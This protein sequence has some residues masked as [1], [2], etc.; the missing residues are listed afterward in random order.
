V[1]LK[2]RNVRDL[3]PPDQAEYFLKE[4]RKTVESGTATSIE[5]VVRTDDVDAETFRAG[6]EGELWFRAGISP[7]SAEVYGR[8]AVVFVPVNITSEKLRQDT[9]EH[10]ANHDSLSGLRNRRYFFEFLEDQFERVRQDRVDGLVLIVFDL[11]RFKNVN[12]TCGHLGGDLVIQSVGD[13]VRRI[14]RSTD[15]SA[16][17]G[18]EEFGVLLGGADRERAV[19][20]AEDLHQ[21]LEKQVFEAGDQRCQVTASF[22]VARTCDADRSV[23]DLYRRAD[24]ALYRSKTGGRNR[25]SVD[26]LGWPS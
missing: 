19:S 15:I 7:I 12:D 17:F 1:G 3:F 24:A 21:A 4:I 10:Q 22:G 6:P 2:G 11:D 9:L 23:S 16:R 18:G 5:Y 13:L 25:V 8:R 20:I 26:P 14:C